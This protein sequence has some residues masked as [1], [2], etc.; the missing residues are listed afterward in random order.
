MIQGNKEEDFKVH[1]IRCR[2][3]LEYHILLDDEE[4]ELA[5]L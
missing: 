4:N 5:E 1:K 3:V 2:K